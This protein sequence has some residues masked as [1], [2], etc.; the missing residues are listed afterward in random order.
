SSYSVSVVAATNFEI[1]SCV[2]QNA[3]AGDFLFNGIM[4]DG[5]SGPASAAIDNVTISL[6]AIGPAANYPMGIGAKDQAIV[7][8]TSGSVTTQMANHQDTSVQAGGSAAIS[9]KYLTVTSSN[10]ALSTDARSNIYLTGC[11]IVGKTS[12][13]IHQV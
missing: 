8:M 4:V 12:G 2:I 7:V 3:S 9:L 5:T 13:N 10:L 1:V 6:N 11:T